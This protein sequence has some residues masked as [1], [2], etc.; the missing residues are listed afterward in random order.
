M[1]GIIIDFPHRARGSGFPTLPASLSTYIVSSE[2]A[3]FFKYFHLTYF[4]LFHFFPLQCYSNR[5]V[6]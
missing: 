6:H 2:N 3:N 4:F 1:A 5:M